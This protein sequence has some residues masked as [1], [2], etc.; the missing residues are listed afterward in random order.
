MH[1]CLVYSQDWNG[2][3]IDLA[4]V[5]LQKILPNSFLKL[6]YLFILLLTRHENSI[7]FTSSPTLEFSIFYF[8]HSSGYVVV[9]HCGFNLMT[10]DIEDVCTCLFEKHFRCLLEKCLLKSFAYFL[11][12]LSAFFLLIHKSS[13]YLLDTSQI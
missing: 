4:C 8:S 9:S 6:L 5:Q 13:L 7:C 10:T 3:V 1:F 2:Q 11:F 12:G